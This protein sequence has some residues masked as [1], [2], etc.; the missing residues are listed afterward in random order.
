MTGFLLSKSSPPVDAKTSFWSTGH[1]MVR[2]G[3]AILVGLQALVLAQLAVV[4]LQIADLGTG[5][6]VV[7]VA[8]C[9][10]GLRLLFLPWPLWCS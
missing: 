8:G 7:Q 10:A 2:P 5:S 6:Q 4:A 3:E 1:L 9:L